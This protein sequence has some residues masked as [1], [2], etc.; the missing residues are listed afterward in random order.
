MKNKY[1]VI[2]LP[3][4][5]YTAKSLAQQSLP[6]AD[7]LL[8][9]AYKEAVTKKKNIFI[10]FHASWC[11]PCKTM[12]ASMNDKKIKAFFDSSYIL[13]DLV[14]FEFDESENNPG[15]AELLQKHND[16]TASI[17]FWMIQDAK[18]NVLGDS[19]MVPVYNKDGKKENIGCP[20]AVKEVDYF[21]SLLRKTSDLTAVQLEAIRKRFRANDK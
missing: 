13:V 9:K 10:I 12:Q 16:S 7:A 14:A 18:G 8:K 20:S 17:P 1:L 6:S 2:L 5:L 11:G 3:L 4:F 15:A 19:R 21:I